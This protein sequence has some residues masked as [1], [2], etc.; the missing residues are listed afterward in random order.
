[1]LQR[2]PASSYGITSVCRALGATPR[3][4]RYYEQ[5]GLVTCSRDGLRR[6]YTSDVF[7]QLRLI[8]QARRANLS[9]RQI[10]H[11][12]S[13]GSGP[14]QDALMLKMV[15]ERLERLDAERSLLDAILSDLTPPSPTAALS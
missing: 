8:V 3:A 7:Q 1:M 13:V 12:L 15:R 4:I 11:L 14:R 9:I 10:R 5:C 2:A 6:I